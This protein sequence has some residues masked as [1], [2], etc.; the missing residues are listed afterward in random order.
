MDTV[1]RPAASASGRLALAV[2]PGR[3]MLWP[4]DYLLA[5]G[6][7]TLAFAVSW[8]NYWLP[9][10]KIFDE[11]YFAR[12]AEEYLTGKYIY[13]NTHPPL[14]KLIITFSTMLFGSVPR[15]DNAAGWRFMDVLFGAIAIVVIYAFAKRLT[16][17]SVFAS[18][19]AILLTA[20]GMHFVQSRIATP[21]GIV[22]VFSLSA[23]YALYRFWNA[24][25]NGTE[26]RAA[27]T[28]L[29]PRALAAIVL[30]LFSGWL[31]NAF[32]NRP[33]TTPVPL[34]IGG[35]SVIVAA[36]YFAVGWYLV[37]RLA[38]APRW[39]PSPPHG[40]NAQSTLWLVVFSVLLGALVSSK[41][42][43]VMLYGTAF[44]VIAFEARR[45]RG[46]ALDVM[47][48]AVVFISA[49]VYLCAW[50]PE[51]VRH[52]SPG[53]T[54]AANIHELVYRQYTMFQYHDQLRA[55]HPYQSSWWQW[56][57]DLRP[58]LYYAHYTKTTAAVVYTL[59]NPL[60]LWF[61]LIS[62]PAVALLAWRE[63]RRGYAL[64]VLAYLLQWLPWAFSPRITFAYHFYVDIPLIV[65]CNVIILQR[66]WQSTIAARYAAFAYVAAVVIAFAWFYPIL[67]GMPISFAARDARLLTW[68]VGRSWT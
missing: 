14:A 36:V 39:R 52:V 64:L 65:L 23:L 59:P 40:F 42:Y 13:E 57:L 46:P 1:R 67:S 61:G 34:W 50:I 51:L 11:V 10:E 38:I 12:A 30:G 66:M 58:I 62:V 17:S 54:G 3:V 15:G 29:L 60:I 43:G 35:V 2:E 53:D 48:T 7:G 63:K 24:A 9:S 45:R 5:G 41:W 56:P 19:A 37:L 26:T 21:E 68:L 32:G 25:A 44:A 22:V 31:A 47:V 27:D 6:F 49:S 4:L 33:A 28:S 20:D 18:A 16:G 8:I 55:T